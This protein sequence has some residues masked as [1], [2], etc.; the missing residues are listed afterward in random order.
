MVFIFNIENIRK[1]KINPT[2]RTEPRREWEDNTVQTEK[3]FKWCAV[4]N[5]PIHL[6]L[7]SVTL[8]LLGLLVTS[9]SR[10][11]LT[12][13]SIR[14]VDTRCRRSRVTRWETN[15]KRVTTRR[16]KG[17]SKWTE[18]ARQSQRHEAMSLSPRRLSVFRHLRLLFV[19][20]SGPEEPRRGRK[21][22]R[23]RKTERR[24]DEEFKWHATSVHLTLDS[25]SSRITGSFLPRHSFKRH[26]DRHLRTV[27]ER[28]TRT[29]GDKETE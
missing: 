24:R 2:R 10:H 18:V 3:Y 7:L 13:R 15:G 14:S 25:S 9:R 19:F 4:S 11:S 29:R 21:E 20:S 8:V 26:S 12:Y 23:W 16:G 28:V 1:N 22:D 5:L 27:C 17:T 6:L